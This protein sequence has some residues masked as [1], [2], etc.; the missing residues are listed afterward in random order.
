MQAS[1]VIAMLFGAASAR[2]P[3]SYNY[4]AVGQSDEEAMADL[5]THP[6]SKQAHEDYLSD[7]DIPN[8][9][10]VQLVHN[11]AGLWQYESALIQLNEDG[12]PT[13]KE[14]LAE[15]EANGGYDPQT[16]EYGPTEKVQSLNPIAY[17]FY[18]DTNKTG[19]YRRART[20]WY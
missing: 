6:E 12:V 2:V 7:T 11:P 9:A 18:Y 1:F 19:A 3:S 20:T 15:K 10:N 16:E 4:F 8:Q 14:K 5:P 13:S 17:Q